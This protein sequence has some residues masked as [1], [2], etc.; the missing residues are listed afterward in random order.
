VI[1]AI[2]LIY[3]LLLSDVEEKTFE[4][5]M[6][7]TLGMPQRVLI[8]LLIIQAF[9][10]A[11]PGL[12]LG[13]LV[14]F[15]LYVPMDYIVST[16]VIIAMD[17]VLHNSAVALGVVLGTI[18]PILGM[19]LPIRRALSRT[20][21]DALDVYHNVAYDS[22]VK[23]QRL[24]NLGVSV[25]ETMIAILLVVLGFIVFYLVPLSF[26][27][28]KIT[29]F[30]N[31]L[32]V[33]LLGMV[34]GQVLLTQAFDFALEKLF[35]YLIMW[36]PDRK[37]IH[38]VTKNLA[39]HRNRNKK[40][41][42]MFTLCLGFVVF[43][44]TMFV[45]QAKSIPQNLQWA[46]GADVVVTAFQFNNPLPEDDYRT[47][48]DSML[49]S[50]N[51]TAGSRLAQHAIV[52]DYTFVT[53]PLSSYSLI[54]GNRVSAASSISSQSVSVL[55]LEA[56][57]LDV[58]FN[59]YYILN[60]QIQG[61]E[62]PKTRENKTDVI[63]GL[64]NYE[65]GNI[66]TPYPPP[67]LVGNYPNNQL[68]NRTRLLD[69]STEQ[70]YHDIFPI[71]MS[72]ALKKG[73]YVD[74]T[75]K[76]QLATYCK[77]YSGDAITYPTLYNL[78]QPISMIT[79]MPGFTNIN[80]FQYGGTPIFVTMDRYYSIMKTAYIQGNDSN[81]VLPLV[82]PKRTLLVR[83]T[84]DATMIQIEG[85]VNSLNSFVSNTQAQVTNLRDQV[86]QT[87][88]ASFL[89]ILFFDLVAIIGLIFSFFVLWLSF[90]ANVRENSWEYG[91]LRAVGLTSST[92]S[93]LYIYE[94]LSLV[95]S[96][97][98]LGTTLGITTAIILTL[99]TLLFSELPFEFNF[100]TELFVMVM[101][102]SLLV[103][104]LGSYFPSE[105][106]RK[107]EIAISLRG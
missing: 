65:V 36:G 75:T 4:Y 55:G 16:Y 17:I 50:N 6:L 87:Q 101:L 71:V 64:Y 47:L 18:L 56:N 76:M 57:Y 49:T 8:L 14:C 12:F 23:I 41:A 91:V 35:V 27:F 31:I 39:G 74:T 86:E 3:S 53:F 85:L 45:L 33:I 69:N 78:V 88:L 32:T 59:E 79:K 92:V 13:F 44:A 100:P 22:V 77:Q 38:I 82:P 95:L 70:T 107:K 54:G 30:L 102:L 10:F 51:Y 21:R 20:L 66:T 19:L 40:T 46:V 61:M 58:V 24:E 2:L 84:D 90:T 98:V 104:V 26:L 94:A 34:I 72:A 89:I 42:I 93:R 5:G 99:Q 9:Y 63:K 1:L 106:Y 37:L 73:A 62:F 7:R 11:A 60:Q 68:V 25:T 48:L 28:N 103:A 96:T 83:V 67:I 81:A 105:E 52:I 43:A 29:M 80:S 97:I 15:L